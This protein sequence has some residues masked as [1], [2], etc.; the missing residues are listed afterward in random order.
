MFGL[1]NFIF[2]P[3]LLIIT[4]QGIELP[5]WKKILGMKLIG[6]AIT[7]ISYATNA[8]SSKV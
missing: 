3:V 2:S 6:M 4:W 1:T 5:F 7:T 8:T